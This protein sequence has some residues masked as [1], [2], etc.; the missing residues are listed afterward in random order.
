M[1]LMCVA[2]KIWGMKGLISLGATE[3]LK[4]RE[5]VLD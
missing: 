3:D 5:F 4:G 1:Q 2:S